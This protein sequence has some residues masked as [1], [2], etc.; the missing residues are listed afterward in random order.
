MNSRCEALEVYFYA[1]DSGNEP[2]R[3]WLKELPKEDKKTIGYDIKTVQPGGVIWIWTQL[4]SMI[5]WLS[6][7]YRLLRF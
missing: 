1:T 7:L 6:L 4:Y 5:L 3:E 2:V